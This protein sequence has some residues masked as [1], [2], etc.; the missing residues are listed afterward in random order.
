M[1]RPSC[2]YPFISLHPPSPAS[3]LCKWMPLPL[4]SPLSKAFN[5]PSLFIQC[6]LNRTEQNRILHIADFDL[7]LTPFLQV[8]SD[9]CRCGRRLSPAVDADQQ[10]DGEA[11]PL[12]L[13]GAGDVPV[14][15]PDLAGALSHRRVHRHC[16]IDGR[17]AA[18]DGA[19]LERRDICAGVKQ[20]RTPSLSLMC[21][22]SHLFL[23]KVNRLLESSTCTEVLHCAECCCDC[24]D[25]HNS[26]FCS[27]FL[28]IHSFQIV[29]HSIYYFRNH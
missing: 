21:V 20:I 27:G 24:L 14:P 16:R 28:P 10:Q 13:T 8:P 9:C 7:T 22:I 4:L 19:A 23:F 3:R 6:T 2:N 26:S 11:R 5:A 17:S 15:R 12:A 18:F 29:P 25:P 1:R